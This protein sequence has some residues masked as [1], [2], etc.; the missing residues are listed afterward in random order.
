MIEV[1][2]DKEKL[3]GFIEGTEYLN[4]KKK[5]IGYLKKNKYKDKSGTTL[6]ILK[7][8]GDITWSEDEKQ[9]YIK[10]SKI[11]SSSTDSVVYEFKKD[12]GKILNSN[13][14]SVLYLKGDIN[15]LEDLDFF[16]IAGQF[17]ELFA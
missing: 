5:M 1:Y 7:D 9:G 3:I 16:G 2:N 12:K 6:L 14:D 17:L 8:N 11:F 4:K 15:K 13:G 10:E